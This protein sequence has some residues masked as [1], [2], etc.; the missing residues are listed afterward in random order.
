MKP[1]PKASAAEAV[2][3]SHP[4]F[5][6]FLHFLLE[7]LLPWPEARTSIAQAIEEGQLD[8]LLAEK[9]CLAASR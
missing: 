2:T 7:K 1:A 5:Q 8:K 3:L 6:V 9:N 4:V